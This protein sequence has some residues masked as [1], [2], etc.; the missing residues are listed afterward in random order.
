MACPDNDPAWLC[1]NCKGN[2]RRWYMGPVVP[3]S[4]THQ[5]LPRT[6]MVLEAA[7]RGA[8]PVE[9]RVFEEV[10]EDLL[11]AQVEPGPYTIQA[12]IA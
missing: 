11:P 6:T 7:A 12:P 5:A 2:G 1:P 3:G 10:K 4:C 9:T 8:P